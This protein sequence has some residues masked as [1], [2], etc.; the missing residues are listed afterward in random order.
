MVG[1]KG[2]AT[3]DGRHRAVDAVEAGVAMAEAAADRVTRAVARAL[4]E[5]EGLVPLLAQKPMHPVV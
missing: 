5:A 1:V 3:T 2:S 4:I